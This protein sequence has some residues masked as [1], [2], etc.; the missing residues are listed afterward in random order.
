MYIS[1]MGTKV[2]FWQNGKIAKMAPVHEIQKNFL[3]K[4]FF[5]GIMKVP[6]TKNIQ[7]LF[8]G[9]PNPEQQNYKQRLLKK[10]SQDFKNSFYLGFL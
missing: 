7:N 2:P 1:G 4:D 8:Q 6:Y 9:L 5:R 10:D 3:P